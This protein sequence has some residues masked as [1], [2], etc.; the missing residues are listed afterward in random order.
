LK[1]DVGTIQEEGSPVV[2]LVP[3]TINDQ[4]LNTEEKR[5]HMT[6]MDMEDMR[7]IYAGS[8]LLSASSFVVEGPVFTKTRAKESYDGVHYPPQ[9]Y[10]AGAQILANSFDWLLP[11]REDVAEDFI[12]MQPGRMAKPYLGLMMLCFIFVGLFYFDGFMGFTHLASIC[13]NGVRPIDLYTEAF[14]T[15]HS[16]ANLPLENLFSQVLPRKLGFAVKGLSGFG[17]RSECRRGDLNS[18]Y[19]EKHS[20]DC[21]ETAYGR[22][23]DKYGRSD[24]AF[25]IVSGAGSCDDTQSVRSRQS[26]QSADSV[27]EETAGLLGRKSCMA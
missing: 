3:T 13:V 12:P 24:T 15:L 11:E 26:V 27:D 19:A 18:K 14:N 16:K 20:D 4:A 9:V 22:T 21:N 6:E 17:S 5:D 2:W 7:D 10:N 25:S 1:R 23:S 8:G